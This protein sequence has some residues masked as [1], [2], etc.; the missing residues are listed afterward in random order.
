MAVN[1]LSDGIPMGKVPF[2]ISSF[3]LANFRLQ[4]GKVKSSTSLVTVR[5]IIGKRYGRLAIQQAVFSII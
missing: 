4:Y 1:L 2:Q 3:Y 5:P